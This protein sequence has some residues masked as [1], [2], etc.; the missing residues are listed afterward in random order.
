MFS[1]LTT[2]AA[3]VLAVALATVGAIVFG[4]AAVRQ[5]DAV[6]T[7][8][9]VAADRPS[10]RP[11]DRLQ[12]QPRGRLRGQLRAAAALVR[13][14]AWLVGAG[15]AGLGGALHVVALTLAPITLVQPIGVL[16]VPTT[17]I[18]GAVRHHRRPDRRQLLGSLLSVAGIVVL[19][20]CLLLPAT[21]TTTVPSVGVLAGAIGLLVAI[22]LVV[23]ISSQ[24]RRPGL[25][26]V[27]LAVTA[28]MLFGLNSVLIRTI[29]AVV[30]AQLLGSDLA[31]A[32]I[33]VL[34]ILAAIPIGIVAMQSAYRYGSPQ[35]VICCL[36]L[37]DPLTA[38]I[39]GRLLLHDGGAMSLPI[40]LGAF[41]GA[42]VTAAGVV[43]LSLASPTTEAELLVAPVG[44]AEVGP[45]AD[46][47][48]NPKVAS[49]ELIRAGGSQR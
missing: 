1:F 34:G 40:L 45:A 42:A 15:Q 12:V 18:A 26:C 47:D 13:D 36:T 16:A 20:V 10:G 33:S 35:T 8:G 32:S 48:S 9:Q 39:G 30:T 5:H 29:G 49:G 3:P 31:L 23:I 44:V 7:T 11:D 38:V 37:M 17:V 2:A 4:L 46:P 28:A 25:G 41:A 21:T 22:A 24:R 6:Q 19:T 43:L 27:A 14:R